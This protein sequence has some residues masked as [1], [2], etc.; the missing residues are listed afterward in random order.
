MG[1]WL[2][3]QP[4]CVRELTHTVAHTVG[5]EEE[6]G[7]PPGASGSPQTSQE[8]PE[9]EGGFETHFTEREGASEAVQVVAVD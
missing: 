9:E 6:P 4:V 3:V 5:R 7:V 2:L 8:T 1:A